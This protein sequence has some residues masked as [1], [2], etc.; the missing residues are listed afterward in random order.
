MT[1]IEKLLDGWELVSLRVFYH[2]PDY[3]SLI[4]EFSWQFYDRAPRWDRT[5]RFLDHWRREIDAPIQ[6]IE[7]SRARLL[8]PGRLVHVPIEFRLN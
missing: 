4:Q 8:S 3:R 7:M 1:D 5:N 6:S 2:N